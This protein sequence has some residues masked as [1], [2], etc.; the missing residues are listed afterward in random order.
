VLPLKFEAEFDAEEDEIQKVQ[1]D[2]MSCIV[3]T[4]IAIRTRDIHANG[5][6][7]FHTAAIDCAR[8]LTSWRS[9]TEL[10]CGRNRL[11]CR[12]DAEVPSHALTSASPL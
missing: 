10:C 6:E 7:S 2:T 12:Q 11:L 3:P 5:S 1:S 9:P 4:A 8:H